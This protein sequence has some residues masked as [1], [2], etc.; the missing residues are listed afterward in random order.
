MQKIRA[1]LSAIADLTSQTARALPAPKI[2]LTG[3]ILTAS[4]LL[5]TALATLTL[6][7]P[8]SSVAQSG[9]VHGYRSAGCNC[10]PIIHK[11]RIVFMRHFPYF[12]RI[13]RVEIP[14]CVNNRRVNSVKKCEAVYYDSVYSEMCE[15]ER[16]YWGCCLDAALQCYDWV[17]GVGV[18]GGAGHAVWSNRQEGGTYNWRKI[19]TTVVGRAGWTAFIGILICQF[20]TDF[21]IPAVNE[22]ATAY[23]ASIMRQFD[24]LCDDLLMVRRRV[25]EDGEFHD[26]AEFFF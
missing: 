13:P 18:V 7:P 19:K 21:G 9:P 22:C 26:C 25:A 17:P 3:G 12:H 10:S 8:Q 23:S 11:A 16:M 4:L 24:N 5:M 1:I 15:V 2:T 20:S 6:W 14:N